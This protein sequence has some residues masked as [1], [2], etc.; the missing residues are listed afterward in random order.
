MTIEIN[1]LVA[2]TTYQETVHCFKKFAQ[3]TGYEANISPRI[4]TDKGIT[5]Q[6]KFFDDEQSKMQICGTVYTSVIF[7]GQGW[8]DNDMH[9]MWQYIMSRVRGSM[10][11]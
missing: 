4:V 3:H 10:F 7:E 9:E 2:C 5:Y 1:I 6:F 8:G 11:K